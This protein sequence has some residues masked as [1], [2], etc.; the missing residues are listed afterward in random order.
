MNHSLPTDGISNPETTSGSSPQTPNTSENTS[1]IQPNSALDND[2]E[3][4]ANNELDTE[5][6]HEVENAPS[7]MIKPENITEVADS[8][9]EELV[10]E[11]AQADAQ[12]EISA[13]N[14]TTVLSETPQRIGQ[15]TPESEESP[16]V[17]SIQEETAVIA[18]LAEPVAMAETVAIINN[19]VDEHIADDEESNE[20]IGDEL[21]PIKAFDELSRAELLEELQNIYA[22]EQVEPK[23]FEFRQIREAY[24]KVK[25]E[26]TRQKRAKY[27]EN[28]GDPESFEVQNDEIDAKFYELV[29]LFNDKRKEQKRQKELELQRNLKRK[30]EILNELKHLM[31]QTENIS[32]SFDQLHKLQAEWR[33]IGLVPSAEVDELWKIYHHHIN[34]FYDVIKI[35]KEL[36][37]LDHKKNLQLKTELCEKAEALLLEESIRKSLDDYK[38]L[39][40]QWKDIGPTG[41]DFSEE[42]WERFK[43][44]GDQLF[45]RRRAYM[46]EQESGYADNL[47]AKTQIC[48]KSEELINLLP[49]SSHQ[50]WQEASDQLAILMENWKTIGFASRKDNELIWKRFKQTRD[51]FYEAKEE[52]YKNLR[53]AQQHNYK[54]KVDLCMEA[55]ALR[56]NTEW[57][58]SSE[59]LKD[60]QEQWK[61]SGPVAKK[62]SDKLWNRF[63][64][65]CDAFFENRNKHFA[66]MNE[67]Q[68]ENLKQKQALIEQVIAFEQTGSPEEILDSLKNFQSTWMEIG[69]VPFKEK[70]K[71]Q[72]AF[73]TAIDAQFSKFKAASGETRRQV[74]KVQAQSMAS[75]GGKEKVNSQKTF[76]QDKIRKLQSEVQVWENNIGFFGASKAADEMKRDIEKKISK[77]KQEIAQMLE[78][79]SILKEL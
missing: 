47:A 17:Q 67:E 33:E 21:V 44:A 41:K 72:K 40:D 69:H 53:Q 35:N 11:G 37:E 2:D 36:R 76:L 22:V 77:A 39:Q 70:E 66:G 74:F 13:S 10:I 50:K 48:E 31:E 27:L 64:K 78:Q 18:E 19:T 1:Q 63:R 51:Q 62:H 24:S 16:V 5:L 29:T 20:E 7:E 25:E 75:S 46:Q 14:E 26:E 54:V 79:I 32:A 57:K 61:K 23:K 42:V 12:Q 43:R 59:R 4:L 55:E 68:D 60:L 15:E 6:T 56:E 8:S 49:L 38:S 45:D 28:E 65:A 3:S 58:K 52:F 9:E 71:I 30:H 73:R 34:N